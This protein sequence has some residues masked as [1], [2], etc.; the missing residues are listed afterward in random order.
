MIKMLFVALAKNQSITD[1]FLMFSSI[2]GP[3]T[4]AMSMS[5]KERLLSNTDDASDVSSN[6]GLEAQED[7]HIE[8]SRRSRLRHLLFKSTVYVLA[9]TGFVTLVH[10]AWATLHPVQARSCNC[11][12]TVS[13]AISRGCK[14]DSLAAAWLPDWCRDDELLAEFETLGPNA[15]GSWDCMS[16]FY[17]LLTTI[18]DCYQHNFDSSIY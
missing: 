7:H 3:K 8:S 5:G 18:P 4:G 14:Y 1:R 12:E 9:F 11:G 2:L 17:A 13:E 16:I 10:Q 6:A 15:D